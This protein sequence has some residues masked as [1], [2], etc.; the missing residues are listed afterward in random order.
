[1]WEFRKRFI[2]FAG[3]AIFSC[4]PKAEFVRGFLYKVILKLNNLP[5]VQLHA[6]VSSHHRHLTPFEKINKLGIVMGK[7]CLLKKEANLD[8]YGN[9]IVRDNVTFGERTFVYTH[10]H[11]Y[12]Q[13]HEYND[14]W[15]KYTVV[16]SNMTIEEGVIIG[17]DSVV[18]SSCTNIGR[19]AR[20][21]NDTIVRTDIPPYAIV[22][23]NPA[24]IIGFVFTP[25]QM[26]EFESH[27]YQE[28][29][30]TPIDKYKR[31]YKRFY[32]NRIQQQ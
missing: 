21:G 26:E 31:I 23:G 11:K 24:K 2:M 15:H 28:D 12:K 13:P 1:M 8:I 25:E 17:D 22:V 14:R 16:P 29:N 4:F 18:L 10:Y 27:V 20:I 5:R 9:L 32:E 3:S 6:V 7:G 19:F 30:R